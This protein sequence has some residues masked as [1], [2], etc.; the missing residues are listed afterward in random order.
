MIKLESINSVARLDSKCALIFLRYAIVL[1]STVSGLLSNAMAQEQD[2]PE[3]FL[4]ESVDVASSAGNFNRGERRSRSGTESIASEAE[5]SLVGTSRIGSRTSVMLRHASGEKVRVLMERPRMRI[6]GYEQYAIVGFE[7]DSV[8][9]QYP[10]SVGCAEFATQGVSCDSGRSVA[11]LKLRASKAGKSLDQTESKESVSDQEEERGDPINPFA[12]A[13][14]SSQNSPTN[15]KQT[16]QFKPRRIDPA[17]VPAGMK[18]VS[19][20]FGDRLVEE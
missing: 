7:T 11:T 10:Q 5:F 17:D 14:N 16:G 12:A 15:P 3:F 18:V 13:I 1:V 20:P 8:S 4:F 19:T 9:I 6:P 2:D